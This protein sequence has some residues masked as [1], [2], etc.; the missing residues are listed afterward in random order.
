MTPADRTFDIALRADWSADNTTVTLYADDRPSDGASSPAEAAAKA[1]PFGTADAPAGKLVIDPKIRGA[2]GSRLRGYV[3][4]PVY[5][6]EKIKLVDVQFGERKDLPGSYNR[7]YTDTSDNG[8]LAAGGTVTLTFSKPV[9]PGAQFVLFKAIY[10]TTTAYTWSPTP[11]PITKFNISGNTVDIWL[12]D[13]A[14]GS[15]LY[16]IG[17]TV[18]ST[19]VNDSI[20]RL[21]SPGTATTGT[22]VVS[23]VSK[24]T[25]ILTGVNLYSSDTN[26][27]NVANVAADNLKSFPVTSAIELTFEGEE[28]FEAGNVQAELYTYS[29]VGTITY[30]DADKATKLKR[31]SIP[32][33]A[34]T[35]T[36]AAGETTLSIKPTTK[37]AFNTRYALALRIVSADGYTIF[38]S[39]SPAFA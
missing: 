25:V 3:A 20:A 2:D 35:V 30:N 23:F 12:D 24:D 34:F 5:T 14:L 19:G 7:A 9:A 22:D 1:L 27:Y 13:A 21:S 10:T 31:A 37:L 28:A 29:S 33:D 11:T 26:V 18:S 16:A 17:Y 6:V 15:A 32:L 4:L 36:S 39:Q 38:N 8:Q